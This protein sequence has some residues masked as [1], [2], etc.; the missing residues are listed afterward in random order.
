[1][2]VG[3]IAILLIGSLLFLLA[4]GVEIA[5]AM[6]LVGTMGL[7][8]FVGQPISQFAF[9][10]FEMMNSFTL[11]AVPLFVLMG[12]ILHSSGVN[13]ILFNA[14]DRLLRGLPGGVASSVI[15]ANAIFGAMSGSSLAATATFGK[16]CYPNMRELG[17]A[18]S[19][20]LGSIAVGGTLSVLIPP[21]IILIIYGG[22][23]NLSVA[24]LF[25]G[26]VIPG[27]ILASLLVLT[28]FVLVKVN[29][30]L[31]P[32]GATG[33]KE[34]RLGAIFTL[35]PFA[36]L[37]TIVLG[38]VFG[39]IM[40]PTE[41]AALGAFLS[42]IFAFAYRKMSY[43][44]LKESLYTAIRITTMLAFLTFTARVLGQVFQYL[45]ITEIFESFMLDLPLGRYGI[46]FILYMM[47]ILLGM[48]FDSL[49]MLLLTFPFVSPLIESLGF[50]LIW[51]GVVY[52]LLTEVGLVTPPFGLNL[53]VLHGVVP[54]QGIMQIVR[55]VLPFL[56][57]LFIT[58]A[59]LTAFHDLALWLPRLL[60]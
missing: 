41:S 30:S 60:Y 9:S 27:I 36:V 7:V 2:S 34:N 20:T 4:L 37:I 26:G 16:I 42:I 51:F 5:V 35:L 13:Q 39:G 53:F 28:V 12:A 15:V 8:F 19:L 59:L 32:K 50:D 10:A 49:S 43:A 21:S 55:G 54:E 3:L 46:L 22:W 25:A 33:P 24:R 47:Y 11:T 14:T 45:G 6:G 1:M 44:A 31:A 40:T 38:S 18:P 17:Y 56:A 48:F 29:P 58:I 23:Q 57:A 52:V